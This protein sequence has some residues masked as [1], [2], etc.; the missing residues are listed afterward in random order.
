MYKFKERLPDEYLKMNE[1]QFSKSERFKEITSKE[2]Y[3]QI[4]LMKAMDLTKWSTLTTG[5]F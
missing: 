1:E 4:P 2:K 5:N 3:F